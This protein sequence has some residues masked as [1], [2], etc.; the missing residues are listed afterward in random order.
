MVIR[1]ENKRRKETGKKLLIMERILAWVRKIS[2]N[3]KRIQSL[4]LPLA[5]QEIQ[6]NPPSLSGSRAEVISLKK[7][8]LTRCC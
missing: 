3:K 6:L 8:E 4:F 5:L 1:I 2:R 7:R